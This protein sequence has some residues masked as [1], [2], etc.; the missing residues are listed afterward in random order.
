MVSFSSDICRLLQL[1]EE[2]DDATSA[3]ADGTVPKPEPDAQGH[4]VGAN[5]L[6][7]EVG[8]LFVRTIIYAICFINIF[9]V[10]HKFGLGFPILPYVA[11]YTLK[12]LNAYNLR[13]LKIE[14]SLPM[15]IRMKE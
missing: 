4:Q 11:Y 1:C 13:V 3:L 10:L 2:E 15:D 7:Q 9:V 12:G 8:F 6:F 14:A 5:V